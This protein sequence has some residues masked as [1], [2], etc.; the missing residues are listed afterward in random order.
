MQ[1][2]LK[3]KKRKKT[4]DVNNRETKRHVT[5]KKGEVLPGSP[6]PRHVYMEEG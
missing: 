1:Q 2:K 6:F 3:D 5:F 4:N